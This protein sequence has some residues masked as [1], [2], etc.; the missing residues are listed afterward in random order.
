[1]NHSKLQEALRTLDRLKE[2]LDAELTESEGEV[3][4][5]IVTDLEAKEALKELL[6]KEGIDYLG[7]WLKAVEDEKEAHKIEKVYVERRLKNCEWT[8]DHIRSLMNETLVA[9]ELTEAAGA[10]GYKF[11][12]GTKT[13]TTVNKT[14]INERYRDVI[15]E[16]AHTAGVPA[17]I[18]ISLDASISKV[19]EGDAIPDYYTRTV[20]GRA[21]FTK[22]RKPS[23]K[24]K[25]EAT[26]Q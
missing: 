6:T 12:V 10:Y 23:T 16:A 1:M 15:Y 20:T 22:P 11:K 13:E 18:T 14:I 25:D 24:K 8:I 19:A 7:G 17:D 21:G 4:E 2:Q 9:A 26:E 3:T 5:Q